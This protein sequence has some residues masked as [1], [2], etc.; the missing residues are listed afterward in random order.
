M[1]LNLQPAALELGLIKTVL[2]ST[3]IQSAASTP[4]IPVKHAEEQTGDHLLVDSHSVGMRKQKS[5]TTSGKG[6]YNNL[7][8]DGGQRSSTK[9]KKELTRKEVKHSHDSRL[10]NVV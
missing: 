7:G 10:S 1:P 4:T 5:S 6:V 2:R 9:K 8:I 3:A